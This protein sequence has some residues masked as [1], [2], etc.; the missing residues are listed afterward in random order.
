M[1]DY[2]STDD[3]LEHIGKVRENL[4]RIVDGL[5]ARGLL[6]DASK[7]RTP[8]KE[9]FDEMTPTYGAAGGFGDGLGRA[10]TFWLYFLVGIVIGNLLALTFS[11]WRWRREMKRRYGEDWNR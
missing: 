2:D 10:M 4:I 3:T 6:H 9:A 11:E 1:S 5:A 8:E 7:L